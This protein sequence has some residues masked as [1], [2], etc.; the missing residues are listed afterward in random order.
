MSSLSVDKPPVFARNHADLA[1]DGGCEIAF[2]AQNSGRRSQSL[3]EFL[4]ILRFSRM[5]E[6][7]AR[8]WLRA[9]L[10]AD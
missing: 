3:L 5:N 7:T 9:G 4:S 1:F 10:A 6:D 8:C 2:A